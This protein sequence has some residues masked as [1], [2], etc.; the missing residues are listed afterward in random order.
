MSEFR[1]IQTLV[2]GGVRNHRAFYQGEGVTWESPLA[3]LVEAEESTGDDFFAEP[4]REDERLGDFTRLLLYLFGGGPDPVAMLQRTAAA[5]AAISPALSATISQDEFAR[6]LGENRASREWRMRKIFGQRVGHVDKFI[7]YIRNRLVLRGRAPALEAAPWTT[8]DISK[9]ERAHRTVVAQAQ[10]VLGG[11]A[12]A[13]DCER[14]L[15]FF[16]GEHGPRDW[17]AVVQRVFAVAQVLCPA[18]TG[19]MSK[20]DVAQML[21]ERKAS[22]SWRAKRVFGA[23]GV[24]VPGNRGVETQ[25]KNAERA[26]ER[27]ARRRSRLERQATIGA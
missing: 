7:L 2:L 1:D 5:V 11:A 24:F 8:P 12:R 15:A 13:K 16:V 27:H 23:L 20:S 3:Q 4:T 9:A 19:F 17:R 18:A 21:G 14:I 22:A 10:A 25:Q 6:L 26:R